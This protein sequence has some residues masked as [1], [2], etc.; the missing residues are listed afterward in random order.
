MWKETQLTLP[1][2]L[3][4]GAMRSGTTSLARALRSRPDVFL[5]RSKELHFFDGLSGSTFEQYVHSFAEARY[6]T[7]I[8]EATPSYLYLPSAIERMHEVIPNARLIAILREPIARAYSHY[9]H[10]RARGRE[11][12]SFSD[13]IDA[14]PERLRVGNT[15]SRLRYSYLDRGRYGPQLERVNRYFARD[16]LLVISFE[17]LLADPATAWVTICS[18]LDISPT[19]VPL[20]LTRK[21]NGYQEFRSLRVRALTQR[22]GRH[23]EAARAAASVLG[24]ANR[25]RASYPPMADDIRETLRRKCQADIG[26]LVRWLGHDLTEWDDHVSADFSATSDMPPGSRK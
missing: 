15:S 16:Q 24:H 6:E 1:N 5:P 14:E 2:F 3:I 21:T 8:G 18:F 25:I 26:H 10:N 20:E 9:W 22:L 11:E 12:L 19:P 7:C 13:A 23:S 17:G 4:I